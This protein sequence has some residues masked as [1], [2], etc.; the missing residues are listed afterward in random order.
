MRNRIRYTFDDAGDLALIRIVY[1]EEVWSVPYGKK[2]NIWKTVCAK[3]AEQIGGDGPAPEMRSCQKR[4][5]TLYEKAVK[6]RNTASGRSGD[7]DEKFEEIDQLLIECIEQTTEHERKLEEAKE[8]DAAKQAQINA[9]QARLRNHTIHQLSKRSRITPSS[10]SSSRSS[11]SSAS[12]S[13]SSSSPSSAPPS[14]SFSMMR[15][16][17]IVV[18]D[19]ADVMVD[20]ASSYKRSR[21]SMKLQRES[22]ET[23]KEAVI[24]VQKVG[25]AI[26]E[27]AKIQSDEVKRANDEMRRANEETKRANDDMRRHM[28][29][30]HDERK[31]QND[32]RKRV[33]DE[34]MR[35]S[36]EMKRANDLFERYMLN[37]N[38]GS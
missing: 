38:S 18:D 37:R 22:V 20:D 24:V 34:K 11:S 14:S 27:Q 19:D 35:L 5:D 8:K 16:S 28:K 9:T 1:A 6:Q 29:R 12:P 36:N 32:E 10:A 26:V 25:E 31:R 17:P 3:L 2:T 15:P 30:V 33:D 21:P 4:Y 7:H 13:S 23:Q